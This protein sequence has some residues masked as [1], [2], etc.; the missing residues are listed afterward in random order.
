MILEGFRCSASAISSYRKLIHFHCTWRAGSSRTKSGVWYA[1]LMSTPRLVASSIGLNC[2]APENASGLMVMIY[3]VAGAFSTSLKTFLKFSDAR[4]PS[5]CDNSLQCFVMV[6][7]RKTVLCDLISQTEFSSPV[8]K[9]C[10]GF[11]CCD[12]PSVITGDT[13][14]SPIFGGQKDTGRLSMKKALTYM[15]IMVI[16]NALRATI[17]TVVS[18]GF[19]DKKSK[20]V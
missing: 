14:F 17:N 15:K 6:A 5:N 10:N 4:F 11:T 7:I 12:F 8:C 16:A 1:H 13:G 18:V 3:Q 9:S 2:A 20:K 19:W